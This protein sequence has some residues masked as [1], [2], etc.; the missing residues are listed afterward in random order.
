M[1]ATDRNLSIRYQPR[2]PRGSW[3][4]ES[5]ALANQMAREGAKRTEI[6]LA[7]GMAVSSVTALLG[8]NWR[9]N[10]RKIEGKKKG[11]GLSYAR[12]YA[13]TPKA[14][15]PEIEAERLSRLAAADRRDLSASIFGD[16]PPG[17]SALDQ[18]RGVSDLV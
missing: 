3:T 15:P 14:L 9:P 16:P 7:V 6:A 4:P 1:T 17:Y 2:K 8:G 5:R 11:G 18:K 13:S 12:L 10:S